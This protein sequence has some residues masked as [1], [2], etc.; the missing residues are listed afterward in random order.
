MK[1]D[2]K[3]QD[4][5]KEKLRIYKGYLRSYLAIMGETPFFKEVCIYDL[6]AG[7]GKD[8]NKYEGSALIAKEEISQKLPKFKA[9]NKSLKLYLNEKKKDVYKELCSHFNEIK[10]VKISNEDADKWI[11]QWTQP[12]IGKHFFFLDPFGYLHLSNESY[13]KLLTPENVEVLLFMP[14]GHYT[15]LKERRS[16]V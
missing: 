15:D 7:K 11:N 14:M 6:F 1:K 2:G 8:N 9:K 5:S 3:Q 16:D 4:H 10:W 13:K 12:K